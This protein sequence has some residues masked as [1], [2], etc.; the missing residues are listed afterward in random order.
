M[1]TPGPGLM[2]LLDRLDRRGAVLV[3]AVLLA[4][5]TFD[6]AVLGVFGLLF[7]PL[8]S[9]VVPIP[10]GALLS[11]LIL[12][13]LV[14]CAH[15]IDPR[16]WAAGAPLIAWGLTVGLVGLTGPGGDVLLPVT[17]QSVLLCAGGLGAGF[18]ALRRADEL[19][20]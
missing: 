20:V 17:W 9:G 2:D 13:W 19:G 15:E 18:W 6:G 10:M 7:N 5:L 11:M 4:V 12:P 3:D 14:T 16:P 8:Y 1:S